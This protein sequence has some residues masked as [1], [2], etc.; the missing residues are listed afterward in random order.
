MNNSILDLVIAPWK[1]AVLNTAIRLNIFTVL[2]DRQ[3]SAKELADQTN[4]NE[5]FL[6]AVLNALVCMGLLQLEKDGYQNS[7]L[8]RIY[9]I[10]G[11][12]YYVGDFI[13]LLANESSKWDKLFSIVTGGKE[14]SDDS[15]ESHRTFIS[16]TLCID[17]WVLPGLLNKRLSRFLLDLIETF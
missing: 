8:S 6:Q 1:T 15:S 3:V 11:E 9:F 14:I 4:A 12:P 5:V 16:N 13:Q 2:S 10:E 17:V 7:H